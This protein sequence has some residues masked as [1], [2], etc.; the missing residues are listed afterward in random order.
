MNIY[1]RKQ[2]WK[3][4]LFAAAVIIFAISLWYSNSLVKKI[5]ADER[6]KVQLWV[7]AIQKKAELVDKN[8][9]L[10]NE[11]VKKIETL[12]SAYSK[13]LS[14]NISDYT[15][16]LEIVGNNIT[17]PIVIA[18]ERGTIIL[19]KNIQPKKVK[20]SIFMRMEIDTMRLQHAPFEIVFPGDRK[21]VV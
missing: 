4:L 7:R 3:F 5:S 11:E 16:I 14:E 8:N 12:A 13:L 15:E 1:S 6:R 2:R 9:K 21:S 19:T 18:D 10:Y 17:I 20:D